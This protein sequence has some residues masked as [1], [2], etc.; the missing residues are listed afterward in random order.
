MV[1]NQRGRWVKDPKDTTSKNVGVPIIWFMYSPSFTTFCRVSPNYDTFS[2]MYPGEVN[3]WVNFH[4]V[5]FIKSVDKLDLGSSKPRPVPAREWPWQGHLAIIKFTWSN[6]F[7]SSFLN[8]MISWGSWPQ[9][10][11]MA[12]VDNYAGYFNI[13]CWM[14]C[15]RALLAAY[16]LS[17]WI[18]Y[19]TVIPASD[20]AAKP[21]PMPLKISTR[22]IP[23]GGGCQRMDWAKKKWGWRGRCLTKPQIRY[24]LSTM[25]G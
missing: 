24:N 25:V 7:K 14:W 1:Q 15:R 16:S 12:E 4:C 2:K 18:Y 5:N 8:I 17:I 3:W 11:R 13:N 6:L 10:L 19:L 21:M 9:H 23:S 22:T 20:T